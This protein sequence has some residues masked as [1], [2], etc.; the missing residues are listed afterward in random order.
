LSR[1]LGWRVTAVLLLLGAA[2]WLAATRPARLGLDLRGGTQIVLEA[3][4]G[5]RQRVDDDTVARTLEVLRRRVDQLGVAEPTLQRSGARRVLVEL[6]GVYDPEEAVR[7]IGRTAQLAFHPVLA[8]AE[9]TQ[10]TPTTTRPPVGE[11]VL[12]DEDGARLRL[13]PAQLTG[14]A[15][16]DARA[17][18]D[19]QLQARWQ[20]AIE[21]QG[22]GGRAGSRCRSVAGVWCRAVRGGPWGGRGGRS[23]TRPRC[24]RSAAGGGLRCR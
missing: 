7:V 4:D 2:G 11:L 22:A 21:F 23:G 17:E 9:P 3:K 10:E 20:V 5:P 19:P 16:G 13:G 24:R 6:P 18:L 14:E 12:A 15:V 1:H 8:V